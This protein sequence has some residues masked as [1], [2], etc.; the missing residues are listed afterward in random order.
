MYSTRVSSRMFQIDLESLLQKPDGDDFGSFCKRAEAVEKMSFA[1]AVLCSLQRV[2]MDYEVLDHRIW[3]Q[4]CNGKYLRGH[5]K[6]LGRQN[7]IDLLLPS[8]GEETFPGEQ[9]T[10][11]GGIPLIAPSH[12]GSIWIKIL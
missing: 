2:K 1:T 10:L 12:Y 3:T 11:L 8:L 7:V 4:G 6:I 5:I 9:T